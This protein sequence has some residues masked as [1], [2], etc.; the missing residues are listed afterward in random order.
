MFVHLLAQR[1]AIP[2]RQQHGVASRLASY[3][4]E[5][6]VQGYVA[7]VV[8][9]MMFDAR[10]FAY[11][12]GCNADWGR[13]DRAVI[14]RFAQHDCSCPSAMSGH[15]SYTGIAV[16]RRHATKFVAYLVRQGAIAPIAGEPELDARLTAYSHWLVTARGLPPAG[17][18]QILRAVKRW[19]DNICGESATCSAKALRSSGLVTVLR[20]SL[21]SLTLDQGD[22]RDEEAHRRFQA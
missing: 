10:H 17:I 3:G 13:I 8:A 2:S 12:V 4:A 16:R 19:Y 6:S 11:W 22:R 15:R 9:R 1:D 5:L 7:K 21:E 14:E 20:R 18:K